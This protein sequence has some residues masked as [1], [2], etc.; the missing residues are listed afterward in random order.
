MMSL[1]GCQQRRLDGMAGAL[2]ARDPRL[3]AMFSTFT[4][5]NRHEPMPST[6]NLAPGPLH[7][8][9]RR[10]RRTCTQARRLSAVLII[11]AAMAAIVSCLVLIPPSRGARSCASLT[12]R[13]SGQLTQRGA[14]GAAPAGPATRHPAR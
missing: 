1:P 14:C 2:Q 13:V 3:A 6:E 4:R 7:R 5:L 8:A 10:I 9:A 11:P 12:G